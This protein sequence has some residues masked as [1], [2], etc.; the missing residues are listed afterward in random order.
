MLKILQ[1]KGTPF[2]T[3]Y[4]A[5]FLF[6]LHI[7]L[8]LYVN[9]SF[10]GQFL[11][12]KGIGFVFAAGS[13]L[14]LL[15]LV[16]FPEMLSRLG[17]YRVVLL[18]F[19][20]QMVF[21]TLLASPLPTPFL[22]LAFIFMQ[23]FITLGLFNL[24]VFLEKFSDDKTTGIA[25][26]IM[27]TIINLAILLGPL[28]TGIILSDSEFWKI[29]LISAIFLVP[30]L[31]VISRRLKRFRDPEYNKVPYFKTLREVLTARHPNDKIRHAITASLMLR[32]FFSWMVIYTPIY[33]YNY[34]GFTWNEIGVILAVML[35]PFVLFEIPIGWLVDTRLGEK[36]IM[37]AG[38]FIMSFFTAVLFFVENQSLVIWAALLFGTRIGASFVE[39][40]SES[41]FFKHIN[42]TETHLLSIFRDSRPVA[43]ILGPLV[44][45]VLL[46]FTDIQHLF[47]ILAIILFYGIW[48]AF[49]M[50][51]V[52]DGK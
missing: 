38:F 50:S 11:S 29:Y 1:N 34:V 8:P 19:A 10:L 22:I 51:P 16:K 43:Y 39:I 21:L 48:N 27:L 37:L 15:L 12:E 20:A 25:R 46:M 45:S 47:L 35:L 17:N 36:Q 13:I 14:T 24:D 7:A 31:F 28:I 23:A 49:R 5:T 30:A 42:S 33:L 32:F 4:L 18:V 3:I 2:F 40:T 44:A 9:S 41:Y 26:G 52:R 6:A